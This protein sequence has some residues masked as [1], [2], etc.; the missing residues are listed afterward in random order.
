MSTNR[1]DIALNEN[2]NIRHS[3]KLI[4]ISSAKY[5]GDW[6]STPHTHN[7]C[8]LFFVTDGIGQFLIED[9]LHPVGANDLIIVNPNVIH[10]E[11]SLNANPL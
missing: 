10:T 5:G 2:K 1:Y 6:H 4:Y 11:V 7:C 3:T 9:Q 8:E